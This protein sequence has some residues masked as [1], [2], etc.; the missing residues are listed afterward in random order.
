MNKSVNIVDKT[1]QDLAIHDLVIEGAVA[2][3][4]DHA[5]PELSVGLSCSFMNIRDDIKELI[6]TMPSD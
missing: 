3:I 5:N 2:I 1:L 6:E 4:N